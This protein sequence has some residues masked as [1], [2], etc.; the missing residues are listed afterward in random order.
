MVLFA[1]LPFGTHTQDEAGNV[2]LGTT[3]S[4]PVHPRLVR[5]AI[6]TSLVAAVIAGAIWAAFDRYGVTLAEIA[7]VMGGPQ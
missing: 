5:K 2:T 6:I 4:A 1:V 7:A 3:S